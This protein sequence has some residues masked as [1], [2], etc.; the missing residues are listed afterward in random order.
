[1]LVALNGSWFLNC[2]KSGVVHFDYAST[3]R[4]LLGVKSISDARFK[5]MINKL[6]IVDIPSEYERITGVSFTQ[7]RPSPLLSSPSEHRTRRASQNTSRGTGVS[8]GMSISSSSDSNPASPRPSAPSVPGRVRRGSFQGPGASKNSTDRRG[9][10]ER[11]GIAEETNT[12]EIVRKSSSGGYWS[13]GSQSLKCDLSSQD[14]LKTVI[15]DPSPSPSPSQPPP[16]F[17]SLSPVTPHSPT[18]N[19]KFRGKVSA[20]MMSSHALKEIRAKTAA[21]PAPILF[22]LTANLIKDHHYEYIDTCHHNHDIYRIEKQ[23][24]VSRSSYVIGLYRKMP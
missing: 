14:I 9:S 5:K 7:G 23:R 20:I 24:D 11:K 8:M 19:Q 17:P 12:T 13:S 6:G 2:P 16:L 4:P 3:K 15:E 21:T 18:K 22:P 1:M 10:A